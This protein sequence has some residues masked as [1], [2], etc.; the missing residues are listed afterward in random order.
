MDAKSQSHLPELPVR[1]SAWADVVAVGV[2]VVGRL[3]GSEDES[4]TGVLGLDEVDEVTW[5][6]TIDFGLRQDNLA[7]DTVRPNY[8]RPTTHINPW[9]GSRMCVLLCARSAWI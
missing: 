1:P 4:M 5:V 9:I 2:D 7:L 3:R 6:S 8:R